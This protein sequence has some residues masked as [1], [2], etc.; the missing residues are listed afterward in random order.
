MARK[1]HAT[2][3][4]TPDGDRLYVRGRTKEELEQ[5][6]AALLVAMGAGVK[7]A[8]DTTFAQ[9]ART[10][11]QV[12]KA[13]PK[14]RENSYATLSGTLEKHVIPYFGA[15]PLK[16]IRPMHIQGF[17]QSVS[18]LSRSMQTKCIQ[19][20]RAIFRSAEDNGLILKS[21]VRSDLKPGG[22][23]AR[24]E[25]AL[26]N[27]QAAALL[28]AVA[29]T[30]AYL[31]CLLALTTGMRRG[32][33][34]GLMW[35]DIDFTRAQITVRHNKV[36]PAGKSDAPVTTL[37]KSSAAHRV[38]PMPLVLQQALLRA[39]AAS[40]SPYVLAMADGRSLSKASFHSLWA[41]VRTRTASDS[42][43]VG[44]KLQGSNSGPL[45]VQLDFTCHPHQLRHTFITQMF[46]SGMDLKQV[47]YLAG[48]STPDMTLRVYTHY[49]RKSREQETAD[50]VSQAV[51]YLDTAVGA[52]R[53][54]PLVVL[55]GGE[56][57]R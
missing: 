14:L 34:L 49:R 10:W 35:E 15:A 37:L 36:F 29:G 48:H 9:F 1:V 25:A 22:Q 31:F 55:P 3:I 45:A 30:R 46:E 16:D 13:P 32:E 8:D 41:I 53:A 12:C 27:E 26:T 40:S 51:S 57:S 42:R 38:L 17:A 6:R 52:D 5:K 54:A 43:P 47:Q 18:G 11:L 19:A 56:R 21:P 2:H 39:R 20:L 4:T 44:T 7:V 24:Q 33:I 23:A 50:L 28:Q